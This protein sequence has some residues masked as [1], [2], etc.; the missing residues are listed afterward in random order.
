[1]SVPVP[2]SYGLSAYK[3]NVG[4][5][6]N[7]GIEI[8]LGFHKRWGDWGIHATGNF[9]YNKNKVLN[10]GGV[11]EQIDSYLINRVGEPYLSFYGYVCDGMFRTQEEADAYTKEY[12]N[13]FGTSKTF[14][15]GDL[16]YK[17]VDGDG[18]LT[19]KNRTTINL[20]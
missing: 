4:A 16:R 1:M 20:L 11:T 15:A 19:S 9:A 2:G 6:R 10:L 17:D 8:S 3:D 14:K 13:P 12:G 5:M 7:S 18:K